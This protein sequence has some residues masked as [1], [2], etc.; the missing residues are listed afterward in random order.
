MEWHFFDKTMGE[1]KM[2]S[3]KQLISSIL[4]KTYLIGLLTGSLTIIPLTSQAAIY[5]DGEEDIF[6]PGLLNND[7]LNFY[8]W[9]IKF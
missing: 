5:V 1:S 3:K 7:I 2:I 8:F 9:M 4:K 6:F